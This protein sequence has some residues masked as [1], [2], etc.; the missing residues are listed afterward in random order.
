VPV[1]PG[2]RASVQIAVG[3][4]DTA[5]VVGSGDVAVLAT[6]RLVALAEA[7]T[8]AAVSGALDAG[9][10]S[11]GTRVELDH[12]APSVVGSR[13]TVEAVL[14]SV[15]ERTLTF[16][17]TAHDGGR[18]VAR[19]TVRRAVVDRERFLERAHSSKA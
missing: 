5:A 14:E 1:E 3:D 11:V 4:G 7:A 19:G 9:S 8:V 15:E 12:L 13:V 10:T 16:S 2:L 6:P 18:E 17:V